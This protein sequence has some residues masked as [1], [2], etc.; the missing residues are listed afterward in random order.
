MRFDD[1]VLREDEGLGSTTAH[2]RTA[3]T[4]EEAYAAVRR[5]LQEQHEHD[6]MHEIACP[7]SRVYQLLGAPRQCPL[8]RGTGRVTIGVII[9][10]DRRQRCPECASPTTAEPTAPCGNCGRR[11]VGEK[12]LT[13]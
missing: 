1:M 4:W 13:T 3:A 11:G 6:M 5:G 8:C 2:V 10:E 12:G 9:A 7:L